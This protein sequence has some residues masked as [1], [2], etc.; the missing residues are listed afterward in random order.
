MDGFE[1]F[2]KEKFLDEKYFPNSVKDGTTNDDGKKLV[3]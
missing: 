2:N 3:T 1:R